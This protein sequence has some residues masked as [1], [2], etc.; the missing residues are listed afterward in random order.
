[1]RRDDSVPIP[2]PT[3]DGETR[4]RRSTAREAAPVAATPTREAPVVE[5][6]SGERAPVRARRDDAPTEVATR[7]LRDADAAERI[8]HGDVQ[9]EKVQVHRP[10]L[11]KR[12]RRG[13]MIAGALGLPLVTLGLITL[14]VPI[15]AWYVTTV[16]KSVI[17]AVA[18]L[19]A[20]EAQVRE[21]DQS[22]T[23]VDPTSFGNVSFWL[24]VIGAVLLVGGFVLSWLVLRAHGVFHP[25]LVTLTAVPMAIG[26]SA[27]LQAGAGALAGLVFQLGDGGVSAVIANALFAL[28]LFLVAS[29]VIAVIVGVLVWLWMGSVFRATVVTGVPGSAVASAAAKG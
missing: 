8:R 27:I 2:L 25:V 15:G 18:A 26:L 7:P 19:F 5:T 13:V 24:I 10:G 12:E 4:L 9:I 28:L 6:A 23:Q 21:L 1:V 3:D 17:M 16:F 14:A 22:I 29:V 20:S 11:G